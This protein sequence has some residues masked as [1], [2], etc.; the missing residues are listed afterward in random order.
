MC[1]ALL[2]DEALRRNTLAQARMFVAIILAPLVAARGVLLLFSAR[3]S[4]ADGAL[5]LA[6][7]AR[8]E[9]LALTDIAAVQLW[10]ALLPCPGLSLRLASGRRRDLA[11]ADP[12]SLAAA[13]AKAGA[14]AARL[15]LPR[16]TAL[17]AYVQASLAVRRSQFDHPLVRYALLSLALALPA[18]YLQQHIAYGGPLGE[19]YTYGLRAYLSGFAIW[20]AAW[21]I[22]VALSDALMRATIDAATLVAALVRPSRVV[23]VRCTLHSAGHALLFLGLPA[24]LL[25]TLFGR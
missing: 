23:D 25:V 16:R 15:A 11:L 5:I 21:A 12:Q 3:A 1:A 20:W 18:F 9:K 24:W 8:H 4:I 10:R 7:G 14:P 22:G 6:R 17:Q 2:L 13:L 19:Y